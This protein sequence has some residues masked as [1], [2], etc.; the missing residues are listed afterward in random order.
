MILT[1]EQS[2]CKEYILNRISNNPYPFFNLN[3]KPFITLVAGYAG[4]GKTFLIS[5]IRKELHKIRSLTNVAFVTFTGKASSVLRNTL[6]ENRALFG[7]DYIGTIHSLIYKPLFKYN[8][9][10]KK[11]IIVGWEKRES[12]EINV[13]IIFVDEASMISKNLWNDLKSYIRTIIAFGDNGQL[14]PIEDSFSLLKFP[15]FQLTDIQRQLETS[16]IIKLAHHV[17]TGGSI[18]PNKRYSKEVFKLSWTDP[19]CRKIFDNIEFD[20]NIILLCGFNHSRVVLNKMIRDK[21]GYNN[22]EPYPNERV[23][24]LKNNHKTKLM[25]GQIG[26]VIWFMAEFKN[27]FRITIDVDGEIY[28]CLTADSQFGKVNYDIYEKSPEKTKLWKEAVSIGYDVD[29]FDYGYAI[30][31]HKSQGS[32]WEKVVL[33]EQRSQYWNDQMYA[34]WFYTAITRARKKLFIISDFY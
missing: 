5:E 25:N 30:S 17:R 24:C 2:D 31:V 15:D 21:L 16:P 8:K 32:E 10:L 26:T 19:R 28:E 34:K 29:F 1:K 11:Q 20:E 12:D 23:I 7:D 33:F 13:D 27:G 4:T 14:P 9:E 18:P 6:N 22:L 3:Y